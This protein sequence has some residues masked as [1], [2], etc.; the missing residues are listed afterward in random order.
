M[1]NFPSTSEWTIPKARN[2]KTHARFKRESFWE[3][4]FPMLVVLF[5]LIGL[6]AL[7]IVLAGGSGTSIV[8]DY[9]LIL[10]FIPLVIMGMPIIALSIWLVTLILKAFNLI[11]PYTY[12]AQ[13]GILDIRERVDHISKSITGLIISIQAFFGSIGQFLKEHGLDLEAVMARDKASDDESSSQG[14]TS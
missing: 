1:P 6:V 14:Q 10:L 4:T 2:P 5:V 3:I 12:V 11:P 7:L 8:A 9:S 13:K